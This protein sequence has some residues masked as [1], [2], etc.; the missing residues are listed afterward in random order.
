MNIFLSIRVD[1]PLRELLRLQHPYFLRHAKWQQ[2]AVGAACRHLTREWRWWNFKGR[3]FQCLRDGYPGPVSQLLC[4]AHLHPPPRANVVDV[5]I[6][7]ERLAGSSFF[8]AQCLRAQLDV[9]VEPLA[10]LPMLIF[11]RHRHTRSLLDHIG[12]TGEA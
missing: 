2:A 5:A 8:Q 9:I 6:R 10:L 11:Y 7:N 1:R 4:E 3:Y 12:K